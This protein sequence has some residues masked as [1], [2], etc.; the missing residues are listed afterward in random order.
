MKFVSE[1][2]I[3][4]AGNNFEPIF[5][6]MAIQMHEQPDMRNMVRRNVAIKSSII[7]IPERRVCTRSVQM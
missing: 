2:W 3:V 6:F 5:D 4:A 1:E 7:E